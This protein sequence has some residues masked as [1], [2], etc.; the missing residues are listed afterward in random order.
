M[1]SR[2]L[3]ALLA[4]IALVACWRFRPRPLTET[5]RIR[6]EVEL[7]RQAIED[8]SVRDL[9]RFVSESYTDNQGNTRESLRQIT[10]AAFFQHP[11]LIARAGVG[12]VQVFGEEATAE[13]NAT[14]AD[15]DG[16]GRVDL[17]LEL[18][19][20]KRKGRWQVTHASGVKTGA[21]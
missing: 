14:I 17:E 2:R 6:N 21:E 19:L 7:A 3:V 16:G 20:A 13:V 4:C 10:L 1:D 12:N 8:G 9:L 18:K 15:R 5:Q 11:N